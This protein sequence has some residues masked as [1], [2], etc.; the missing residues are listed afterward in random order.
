MSILAHRLILAAITLNGYASLGIRRSI[1]KYGWGWCA[2]YRQHD[3]ATHEIGDICAR[4]TKKIGSYAIQL[5]WSNKAKT[6]V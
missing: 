6:S 3:Q 1:R 5:E 4:H 2:G